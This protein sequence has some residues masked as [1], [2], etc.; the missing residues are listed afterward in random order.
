M[1]KVSIIINCYNGEEFLQAALDSIKGQTFQDYD[2]IFFDNCSTDSS[3]EI[4]KTFGEK[5]KYYYNSQNVSLGRARNLALKLADGEYIAFLDCD[6]LWEPEKLFKQ[7]SILDKYD[8]CGMIYSN[9]YKLN[10]LDGTKTPYGKIN[11]KVNEV[12]FETFVLNY[13]YCMSSFLLRKSVLENLQF[14]FDE[15]LS[16]AEEF[17]LFIRLAYSCKILYQFEA[18]ASYRIHGGMT[19][20]KLLARIPDE[21]DITLQNLSE[22]V[23]DLPS[24]YP[25]IHMR[26]L[27]LRDFS[28]S[29][30][31][32][33]LGLNREARKTIKN[34][35]FYN[36]RS[37]CYYVVSFFPPKISKKIF[38]KFYA[39]KI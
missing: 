32:L 30:Y 6:D 19:S 14:Y 20:K 7:V 16:F 35:K 17:D 33:S 2:I 4:A 12:D 1:P 11:Y 3:A 23:A 27:Y 38:D 5:L 9:F 22:V 28:K 13:S 8:S 29:K 36:I 31:Y 24:N 39:K 15:R 25:K 18:L 21:Y 10:M 26:I 34:F 37:F